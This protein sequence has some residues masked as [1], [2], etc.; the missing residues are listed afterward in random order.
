MNLIE[1]RMGGGLA[2]RFGCCGKAS[3]LLTVRP[4]VRVRESFVR[5]LLGA[6]AS[7]RRGAVSTEYVIIV[8]TVSLLAVGA[9]VAI[10]PQLIGAYDHARN[11][12]AVP[13]P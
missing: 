12:L 13:F 8:G 7:D 11:I 10:G 3:P 5:R 6:V 9:F 2:N 4:E 1:Q